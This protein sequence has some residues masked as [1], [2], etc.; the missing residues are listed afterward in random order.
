MRGSWRFNSRAKIS[1]TRMNRPRV[2][3]QLC[4]RR[5]IMKPG[6]GVTALALFISYTSRWSSR[7]SFFAERWIKWDWWWGARFLK[8]RCAGNGLETT[9][10][11]ASDATVDESYRAMAAV[12][13]DIIY[14]DRAIFSA[15]FE[16][17][18]NIMEQRSWRNSHRNLLRFI[19]PELH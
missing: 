7:R 16:W 17:T 10:N 8:C 9:D 5:W 19:N 11:C 1:R 15:N 6:V 2:K 13:A 3:L 12:M 14:L 4:T 18:S